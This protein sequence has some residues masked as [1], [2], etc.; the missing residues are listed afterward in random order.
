MAELKGG[1]FKF[2]LAPVDFYS[3]A[4]SDFDTFLRDLAGEPCLSIKPLFDDPA[5]INSCIDKTIINPLD[6]TT[7]QLI[8]SFSPD[9]AKSYYM[10]LD[11]SEGGDGYGIALA[12]SDGYKD[13]KLQIKV[14]MLGCPSRRSYGINFKPELLE[15]IVFEL[16]DRGFNIKICTYDRATVIRM[17]KERLESIGCIVAPMSIDRCTTYPIID[18]DQKEAPYFRQETTKGQY[19]L[20]MVDF[21]NSINNGFLT[22]P[23]H[24]QWEKIPYAFEM[25]E[26]KKIVTKI[27]GKLDDL[28]Q[29]CAGAV[30]HVINNESIGQDTDYSGL[31]IKEQPDTF[32]Q[33]I[34]KLQSIVN[35]SP[36]KD[37]FTTPEIPDDLYLDDDFDNRIQDRFYL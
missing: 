16:I 12:S 14:D 11:G 1:K 8:D 32:I 7:L 2:F 20:P 17:I 35:T 21:R 36:K 27:A 6:D 34:E 37:S 28:G 23:Y 3:R 4:K 9:P 22:V 26:N 25:N 24:E 31:D 33:D 15:D 5:K 30:F 19:Y 13:G 29:A 10:H 18:Y